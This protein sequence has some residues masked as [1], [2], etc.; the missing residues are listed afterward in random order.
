MANWHI[1]DKG[2]Q[3]HQIK[4]QPVDL[5]TTVSTRDPCSHHTDTQFYQICHRNKQ[6]TY[7]HFNGYNREDTSGYNNL[8]N[9][10]HSLYNS[11]SYQQIVLHIRSVLA[12]LQDSLHYIREI[13]LHT[14][15]YINAATTG[16]LS[17]LILPV[18]DLRK[19]LRYIEDTLPS[20]MHLPLSSDNTLNFYRYLCTH[21]PH[22]KRTIPLIDKCA[23]TG[24]CTANRSM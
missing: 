12:N 15:D 23:N 16:V 20:M 24:L 1:H 10:M 2:H 21:N 6:A 17:P 14:M 11:I 9:I 22:C 19:M 8:Y 13:T 7:Q 3:L 5:H 4:D 18:Q